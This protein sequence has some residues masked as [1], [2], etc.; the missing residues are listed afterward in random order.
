MGPISD[1]INGMSARHQFK[2][3]IAFRTGHRKLSDPCD[4]C[5]LFKGS[6]KAFQRF[7]SSTSKIY[8]DQ[9]EHASVLGHVY[10]RE[11][12]EHGETGVLGGYTQG[13]LAYY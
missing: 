3:T 9:R 2:M 11:I 10:A 13:P 5:F 4:R 6:I 1:T 12:A 7:R 8:S